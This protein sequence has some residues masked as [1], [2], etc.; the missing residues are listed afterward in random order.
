MD[1]SAAYMARYMAKNL[2]AAGVAH[3]ALVQ[4][5]YAIG[6]AEP[7]SLNVNTNGTAMVKMSDGEIAKKLSELFDLRPYA[8]EQTLHLREPIYTESASYGHV[9]RTPQVVVKTFV[10]GN[11]KP[12]TKKVKLFSWEELDRVNDIKKS[13][14][15]HE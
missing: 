12:F 14:G 6:V 13:F 8:I 2:V 15:I 10:D 5:S 9:G 4:I 3:E 11:G 1:R 7:V